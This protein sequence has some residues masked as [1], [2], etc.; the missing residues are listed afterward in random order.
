MAIDKKKSIGGFVFVLILLS[1]FLTETKVFAGA[2]EPNDADSLFEMSIEQLMEIQVASSATLTESHP[3]LVPAAV[4]T[5]TEDEIQASGARSLF[6]LLDIYVPNLQWW[7]NQ[8]EADNMGLRGILSDHDDKYLLL[9]N[10][11]VMNERTHY[12][13]VS[14]RDLVFMRDI[15]HIDIVRGPGSALY[16]PGAVAMVINIVTHNAGTFEGTEVT[17]RYG[18]VEYFYSGEVKHGRKIGDGNDGYFLYLGVAEYDGANEDDAP[19]VYG[20][21]FP[22]AGGEPPIPQDSYKKGE[23][24]TFA[25]VNDGESARGLPPIKLYAELNK[26]NWNYWVRYTRGGKQFFWPTGLVARAP[27]GWTGAWAIPLEDSFYVYQQATGFV[28]Y[29]RELSEKTDLEL[30]F[31]YD[32][33]DFE[34]RVYT[35]WQEAYREDKYMGKAIIRHDFNK[36]HKIAVGTEVL[37]GEYGYHSPG[38]P[39]RRAIDGTFSSGMPRWSSNLYSVFGEHQWTISERWT[40]FLG[41][42]IDDHT[43]TNEMF[44]PRASLVY[45]PGPKSTYKLMWSR[46]VR[47]NSEEQMK[48][49]GDPDS[50]PEKL[51]SVELRYERKHND[52]LDLAASIF[53]HYELELIGHSNLVGGQAVVGTSKEWGVELEAMYHTERTRLGI[54]HGYTKLSDF[55]LA[56]AEMFSTDPLIQFSAHPYGYGDDLQRWANHITKITGQRKLNDKWTLDGSLRVYWGFPGLKDYAHYAADRNGYL[57]KWERSYRPSVFLNLGLQYKRKENMT[58][59]IDGY[60]L[61]GIFDR[62]LNKRNKG[63]EGYADFRSHAPAVAVTFIYKY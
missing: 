47:A 2:E 60:N 22:P 29:N 7:R 5:I 32:M 59:R 58:F 55:E 54:S 35:W 12:G 40:S 42:R 33:F 8:W 56:R 46:S 36:R 28:G 6:E 44:S 49:M 39:H 21:E 18:A 23:P 3:R 45:T 19:Q 17:G 53:K 27:Y 14:E 4:T 38:Y 13:A 31:S 52:N 26:G 25:S 10:G 34:R 57:L 61:L 24:F 48:N 63:G 11:R 62:D 41:A 43:F 1:L 37:H 30:S 50:N 16:G 20:V 9:V 15:H 51:D